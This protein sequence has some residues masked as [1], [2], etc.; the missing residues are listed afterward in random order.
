[1]WD[2]NNPV[3]YSDPTGYAA[4]FYDPDQG[5]GGGSEPEWPGGGGNSQPTGDSSDSAL[6]RVLAY[7]EDIK[8]SNEGKP[9]EKVPGEPTDLDI[10]E[11]YGQW[12][13]GGDG[14]NS[15]WDK[16]MSDFPGWSR[17]QYKESAESDFANAENPAIAKQLGL[18]VRSVPGIGPVGSRVSLQFVYR[19]L[20][21][22]EGIV[23]IV[24][25]GFIETYYPCTKAYFERLG[26]IPVPALR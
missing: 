20:N 9:E 25:N 10:M 19:P 6:Q 13:N 21:R 14:F 4:L 8:D 26:G 17:E 1:M 12:F 18:Q 16:H 22:S 15:K 3:N 5:N 7:Q 11:G 24:R 23:M 2:G